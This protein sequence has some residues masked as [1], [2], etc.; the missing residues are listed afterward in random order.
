MAFLLGPQQ[1]SDVRSQAQ[2]RPSAPGSHYV[3]LPTWVRCRPLSLG[4]VGLEWLLSFADILLLPVFFVFLFFFFFLPPP[5]WFYSWIQEVEINGFL[6]RV[7]NL[8][9]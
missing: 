9:T 5:V 8:A 6:F 4:C 3:G 7:L 2:H 1:S